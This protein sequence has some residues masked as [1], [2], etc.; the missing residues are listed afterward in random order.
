MEKDKDA[1]AMLDAIENAKMVAA[2]KGFDGLFFALDDMAE[3]LIKHYN[4][5]P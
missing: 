4:L 1:L 2:E 5:E 3:G